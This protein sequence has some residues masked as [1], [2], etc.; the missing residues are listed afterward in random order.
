M[1]TYSA[2]ALIEFN[3]I[4]SG[5]FCSDAM[6]K[7]APIKMLKT[8]T[9]SRGKYLILIGGSVASVEESF[10]TGLSRGGFDVI[11]SVILPAVHAQVHDSITGSRQKPTRDSLGIIETST[12]AS[13]LRIADASVKGADVNIIEMRLGD[14]LGGKGIVLFNGVL[15]DVEQ[16]LEIA[17]SV[18]ENKAMVLRKSIIPRL[19]EDLA[20]K[21]ST[22]TKFSGSEL[23]IL[24]DGEE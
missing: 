10:N 2:V 6:I 18:S 14:S 16:A 23:S 13:L 5:L 19:N 17:V 8:G 1:S 11:D 12:I 9:I 22:T 21:I 4:T 24:K 20:E 7:Q 3:S 15:E